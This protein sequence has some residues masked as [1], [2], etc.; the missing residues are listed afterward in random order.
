MSVLQISNLTYSYDNGNTKVLNDINLEFEQGKVYAIM[1]KSGAGK[2]T[3]LSLISGLNTIQEG[4]VIYKDKSVALIDKD[5]Y[6]SQEVGIVFQSFNLILHLTA[7]EN[8]MLAMDIAGKKADP[9]H[10][11]K[12]LEKVELSKEKASR[13]VLQLS[14]GEQQRVAIARSISYDPALVIADEPTGNLDGNTE[15]QVLKILQKL[16]HKDN[17][18]VIIVTH[19]EKVAEASDVIYKL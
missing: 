18:C 16:A 12:M 11:M 2:T 7:L 13:R 8:V 9:E 19:S 14:G 4:K 5:V 3:L 10:A 1:G 15:K 6:R 17:K